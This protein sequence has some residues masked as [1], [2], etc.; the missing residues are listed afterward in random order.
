M[1]QLAGADT[2]QFLEKD[3]R[4]V[5]PKEVDLLALLD[6]NAV[7]YIFLYKSVAVQHGLRYIELSD[8]VNLSN[9]ELNEW[10]SNAE[11]KV[12]GSAPGDTII[13][14]GEAMVYGVTI[15]KNSPNKR[16]AE[17]FVKYL[18]SEDGGRRILSQM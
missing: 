7:D 6:V 2:K 3:K 17:E 12:R 5:R 9:P 16:A 15:L 11:V 1:L 18:L 8:S 13:I 4:F 10:Y 14:K